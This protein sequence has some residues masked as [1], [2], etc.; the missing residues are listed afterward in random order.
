[1]STT[2]AATHTKRAFNFNA[3]PAALPLPVLERIREELLDYR[4]TGMSV[5]ELSHRSAEFEAINNAAE[6]NL[7]KLLTIPDDYAVI[8]VQGG[9]SMQFTMVPMN[10]CLPE[11]PVDVLHTGAWTAKAIGELKKG[12]PHHIA[13]STEDEKFTRVPGAEEI[14]LSTDSSYTYYCTNNT[15]EGTQ[16]H[17][18]PAS[19]A[20]LVADMSSDICS[21]PIDV[22]KFGLIFA[23]AQKN[24]GPSGVTVV[25]VRKDLAERADKN[26]PTV[27]QYRTQIKEKSLYNTPPTFAVYTLGLVTE[28]IAAEGGLTGIQKRNEAKA[29]LLY[30]TIEGSKGF[31]SC[32]VEKS[33]R[34]LMNVVFR[35]GGTSATPGDEA[36]EKQFGKDA[37]ATNLIGTPGHRSVGGMRISLYN[38]VGLDA[39]ESLV[40]F[41]REF[42]RIKS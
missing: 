12:I 20:P 28:W 8:F 34:S 36:L 25:I 38:A 29:K 23:G 35:V 39:V 15:I 5:M 4:G 31:Y 40:Q 1:V 6:Q 21:C 17:S 30:D 7:R 14:R 9:G 26:L 32:P 10:L 2:T 24:L 18:V 16:Y 27:L 22:S 41:M 13:A 33:S 42:Q 11:K 3:G 37:T 19:V